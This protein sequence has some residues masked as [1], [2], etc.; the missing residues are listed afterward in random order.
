MHIKVLKE[1]ILKL[2]EIDPTELDTAA[3]RGQYG[4]HCVYTYYVLGFKIHPVSDQNCIIVMR[5]AA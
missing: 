3:S 2:Y 1:C 4:P 5:T